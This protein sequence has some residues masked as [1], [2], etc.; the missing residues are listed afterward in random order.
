MKNL[1]DLI[2][3]VYSNNIDIVLNGFNEK[4]ID[5]VKKKYLEMLTGQYAGIDKITN[6]FDK[7]YEKFIKFENSKWSRKKIDEKKRIFIEDPALNQIIDIASIAYQGAQDRLNNNT[8]MAKEYSSE[9]INKLVELDKNVLEFNKDLS[10]WYLSEAGMDLT[11]ACGNTE[12]TSLR[13]GHMR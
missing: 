6:D 9:L 8:L 7:V 2:N 10:K 3:K 1:N 11:Y 4:D 5:G 13:I 12:N